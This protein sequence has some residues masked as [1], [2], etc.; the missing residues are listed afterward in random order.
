MADPRNRLDQM[1]AKLK[2]RN[3]RVTPQ[4]LAILKILASSENHPSVERIYEQVKEIL[5]PPAWPRFTKR[6]S[7][8][9]N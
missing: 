4:R 3:F 2:T 5:P 7:C 1:L 8:S 9:S 6:S